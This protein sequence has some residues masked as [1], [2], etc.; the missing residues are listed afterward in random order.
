MDCG[1]ILKNSRGSFARMTGADRFLVQLTSALSDR[2]R[3]MDISR[4]R[5]LGRGNGWR[6]SPE[7]RSAAALRR[8]RPNSAFPGSNRA[9]FGSGGDYA[10]RVVHLGPLRALGRSAAR[11]AATAAGFRGGAR[12]SARVRAVPGSGLGANVL[13]R[14]CSV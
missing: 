9:G 14:G 7:L 10:T 1:W 4:L 8:R 3:Q 12:R 6:S 11:H 5:G 2:S 13:V